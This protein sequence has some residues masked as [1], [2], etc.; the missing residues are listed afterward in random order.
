MSNPKITEVDKAVAT[1]MKHC[2]C[3]ADKSKNK[4]KKTFFKFV[5]VCQKKMVWLNRGLCGLDF[6]RQTSMIGIVYLVRI[7]SAL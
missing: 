5:K 2:N 4:K 6:K 7:C 3:F 1:A